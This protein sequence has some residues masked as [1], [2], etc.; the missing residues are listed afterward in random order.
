M[1]DRLAHLLHDEATALEIPTVATDRILAQGRGIQRRRRTT[2]ATAFAAVAVLVV[3][4]A[5][6]AVGGGREDKIEP[7][8]PADQTAYRE[9]GAWAIGDELHIGN[10][11]VTVP[12]IGQLAYTSVGVLV[13]SANLPGATTAKR[14]SSVTTLVTPDGK[15]RTLDYPGINNLGVAPGSDPTSPYIAYTR[16]AT[17]APGTE[18]VVIDLRN[19]EESVVRKPAASNEDFQRTRVDLAGDLAIYWTPGGDGSSTR[20]QVNWRTG[21]RLPI[22]EHGMTTISGF[23]HGRSISGDPGSASVAGVVRRG[24]QAAA[25]GPTRGQGGATPGRP[26][27]VSGRPLSLGSAR[28]ERHPGLRRGHGRLGP[29][30]WRPGRG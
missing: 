12:D 28:R 7:A 1:T 3:G 19:G 25:R 16:D 14:L 26:L 30:R 10:R 8:G 4:I 21:Q 20:V 27:A 13:W 23:A 17:D 2:I 24:R 6:T 22:V 11:V 9:E 29:A 5:V 15:T 18:L